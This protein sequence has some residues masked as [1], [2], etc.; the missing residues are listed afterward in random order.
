M[1][2]LVG[3]GDLKV[4]GQG[5]LGVLFGWLV[6]VWFIWGFFG[7]CFVLGVLFVFLIFYSFFLESLEASK[8]SSHALGNKK[9]PA[10]PVSF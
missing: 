2:Q 7:G 1:S 9:K 6:F 4:G 5:F 10:L 3:E 8:M